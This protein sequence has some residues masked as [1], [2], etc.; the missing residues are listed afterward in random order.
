MITQFVDQLYNEDIF[1]TASIECQHRRYEAANKL[2]GQGGQP[3]KALGSDAMQRWMQ[4]NGVEEMKG[5]P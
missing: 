5:N 3:M 4:E 1:N 2:L